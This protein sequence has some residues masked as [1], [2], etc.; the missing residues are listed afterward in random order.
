MLLSQ[1]SRERMTED[2]DM[3]CRERMTEDSDMCCRE[4]MTED[5]DRGGFNLLNG[6]SRGAILRCSFISY[7]IYS[8]YATDMPLI[9]SS[10]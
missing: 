10:S 8:I 2:S 3:C 7:M 4:R 9:L 5:R 1:L 6:G